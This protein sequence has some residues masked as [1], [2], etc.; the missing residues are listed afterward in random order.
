VVWTQNCDDSE[1]FKSSKL[2]FGI[3]TV[4]DLDNNIRLKFKSSKLLFGNSTVPDLD[5]NIRI[6][7]PF[8]WSK[9]NFKL[10]SKF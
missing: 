10:M 2:L 6:T 4:P 5:N 7:F 9:Y 1:N 8:L 3:S